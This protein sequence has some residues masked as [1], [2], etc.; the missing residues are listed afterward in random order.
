LGNN[1]ATG[2]NSIGVPPDL[3]SKQSGETNGLFTLVKFVSETI[4]NSNMQQPPWAAR[5]KI[6]KI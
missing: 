2:G 1:D 6:E 4:G 5:H 3:K